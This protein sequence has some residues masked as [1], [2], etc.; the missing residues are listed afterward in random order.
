MFR[1]ISADLSKM[2][3]RLPPLILHPFADPAA[4]GR[5]LDSSRAS[6]MLKGLL[7]NSEYTLEDLN[8]RVLDG[9]F[10]EI[11]MLYYIGKDLSRWME[12]CKE[13]A[14]ADQSLG[15]SGIEAE[16]FARM[17]VED[18]PPAARAK[19][20]A[21]GVS[22]C[23]SIFRRALGFHAV[24]ARAPERDTLADGFIRHHY[25]Y[26]DQLYECRLAPGFTEIRSEDFPFD[27]FASGEYSRILERQWEEPPLL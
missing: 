24:F 15:E 9:R 22:D 13:V 4:P 6:L 2:P 10:F 8:Q 19:M 11:R 21:W 23:K 12:Q 17:L 14:D 26:G 7:P 18:L 1:A 27:I 16:S 20:E 5:L 25:R 3:R